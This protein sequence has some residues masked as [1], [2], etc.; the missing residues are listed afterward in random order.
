MQRIKQTGL[1]LLLLV[2]LSACSLSATQPEEA[3][4]RITLTLAVTAMLPATE[5][6][7]PMATETSSPTATSPPQSGES[8][9]AVSCN[10]RAD[11]PLYTVVSGDTLANIARLVNSTTSVLTEANCLGNPNILVV[12]QYIRVPTLPPVASQPVIIFNQNLPPA[13]V[14]AVVI[15][16]GTMPPLYHTAN[17][18]EPMNSQLGNWGA[19]ISTVND[20]YQITI[21]TGPTEIVNAFVRASD[22]TL[23]GQTCGNNTDQ[24][25]PDPVIPIFNSLGTPPTSVCVM[26]VLPGSKPDLFRTANPDEPLPG[27]LGNWALWISTVNGFHQIT[28]RTGSTEIVN[29]FV[30]TSDVVFQGPTCPGNDPPPR[31]P[32]APLYMNVAPFSP[33]ICAA[34]AGRTGPT[35]YRT[36]SLNEP[37]GSLGNWGVWISTVNGFYQITIQTGPTEIVNTFVQMSDVAL[38]GVECRN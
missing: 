30:S 10:P 21:Q 15:L 28:I 9:P 24:P 5:T 13:N 12:G 8:S 20:F 33:T 2:T 16:Q 37:I 7:E 36:A 4:Q 17:A 34:E 29:A 3:A 14:C 11:W 38:T 31:E 1:A 32:L 27:I 25:G 19:W 6:P 35:L 22:V 23:Q 26:V 18:N